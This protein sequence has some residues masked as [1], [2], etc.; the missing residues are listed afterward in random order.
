MTEDKIGR[1]EIVDKICSLVDNL[2]KDKHFCLALNGDWGSGKTFVMQIIEEKLKTNAE[3]TVIKYDAWENN[4]YS[5]PLISILSC[6]IDGVQNKLSEIQGGLAAGKEIAKQIKD[7]ALQDNGKIGVFARAIKGIADLVKLFNKPFTKD[8]DG[9]NIS[10]FKSYQSLLKEVKDK[11]NLITEYEEY[12]DKQN[13]LII[14]V[15][16]IDRCLPDEQLKILERLHHLFDVKN[17]AVICAINKDCIA[18]NVQTTYGIDGNE[19]LRKFFDFNYRLETNAS[20]YLEKLLNG[21][22]EKLNSTNPSISEKSIYMAYLCLLYGSE[23]VLEKVDNRELD[24]YFDAINKICND[25]GWVKITNEY[26][27]FIVI[28]LF[29]RK[30]ISQTFLTEKEIIENQQSIDDGDIQDDEIDY[31]SKKEMPYY[32]Y[33]FEYLGIDK[34]N[35]PESIKRLYVYN[36]S[37]LSTYIWCF[38]ETVCYSLG[39]NFNGNEMRAFYHQPTVNVEDC[40]KLRVLVVKYGGENLDTTFKNQGEK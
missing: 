21:F 31:N 14:L 3:Y 36:Y 27:F 25:F 5:D 22:Y 11:L 30:N 4:F 15:D 2:Q 8:T 7:V 1:T 34:K 20:I 16:E 18:K 29:I 6:V 38:N 12:R 28:A 40:K 9:K 35:L 32:D 23:N 33:V 13:K 10:G 37:F 19:Y 26:S 39:G 24:R 17:C